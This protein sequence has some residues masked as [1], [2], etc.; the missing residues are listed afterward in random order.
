MR[1]YVNRFGVI[2]ARRTRSL[3][4]ERSRGRGYPHKYPKTPKLKIPETK[5][6]VN[7]RVEGIEK[8][9]GSIKESVAD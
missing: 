8:H 1:V 3:D 7:L 9:G 6:R 2:L 4:T 5:K